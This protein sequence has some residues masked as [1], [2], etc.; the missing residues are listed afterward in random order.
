MITSTQQLI[1]IFITTIFI[2]AIA[3]YL[4]TLMFTKRMTLVAGPL[5]HL[6]LPGIALALVCG[7]D[8][9]IG[10]LLFVFLGILFI[11]FFGKK[12]KIPMEALVAIIFPFSMSVAFLV[13][14]GEETVE[15]LIGNIQETSPITAVTSIL[16]SL[17]VFVIV[18]SI[19]K[20]IVFIG[21]SEDIAKTEGLKIHRLNFIYLVCIAFIVA[22]ST[23]VVGGLMTVAIMAIPAAT[24]K[25][26]GKSLTQYSYIGL[27]VGAIAAVF[28]VITSIAIGIP[29]GPAIIIVNTTIFIF[30][31]LTR[32]I[33]N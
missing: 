14:P 11:W 10:A 23:K 4:G 22:L 31:F 25:L 6:T 18:K 1:L 28:G 24:S 12:T 27:I 2:G 13:L 26:L 30:S 8:T 5:G 29:I 19:Y 33:K 20:K 17:I 3:G 16:I 9:F 32:F 7:F 15:A 21:V